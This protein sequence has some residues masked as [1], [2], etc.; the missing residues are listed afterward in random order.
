MVPQ[1]NSSSDSL[2]LVENHSSCSMYTDGYGSTALH[3]ACIRDDPNINI[4]KYLVQNGLSHSFN[5]TNHNGETALDHA[6]GKGNDSCYNFLKDFQSPFHALCS[7]P[8]VTAS[9]IQEYL[10]QHEP[11][12][13][14]QTNNVSKTPLHH[15]C[16]NLHA[17]PDAVEILIKAMLQ[18][19]P[20]GG[21]TLLEVL[22]CTRSYYHGQCPIIDID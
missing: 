13:V 20:T 14:F 22:D 15:L 2:I 16:L 7:S 1:S 6:K 4:V 12:C 9:K 10:D 3:Y 21:N 18:T 17:P 19:R 5:K 11:G 8:D